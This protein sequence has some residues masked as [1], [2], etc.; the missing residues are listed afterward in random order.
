MNNKKIRKRYYIDEFG[1]EI[2]ENY[3]GRP[4]AIDGAREN[5]LL[6]LW[7][8][9]SANEFAIKGFMQL[10]ENEKDLIPHWLIHEYKYLFQFV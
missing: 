3:F 10:F 8:Q 1:R 9:S 2:V 4:I 7:L 5:H 6:N